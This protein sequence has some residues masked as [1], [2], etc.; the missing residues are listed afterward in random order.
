MGRN[1]WPEP[2]VWIGCKNAAGNL[3]IIE[4]P[5]LEWHELEQA[6]IGL[7]REH[8]IDKDEEPFKLIIRASQK[9]MQ[10]LDFTVDIETFTEDYLSH[11]KTKAGVE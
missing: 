2:Y 11:V 8:A 9:A 3:R 1:Q 10:R 4:G 7:Y 5:H 6:M